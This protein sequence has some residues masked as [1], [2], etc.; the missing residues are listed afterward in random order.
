MSLEL[1]YCI[2]FTYVYI[3]LS[4]WSWWPLERS[5]AVRSLESFPAFYGTALTRSLHLYLSWTRRIQSTS[6]HPMPTRSILTLSVHLHHVL[7]SVLFLSGYLTN[8]LYAVSSTHSCY[9]PSPPHPPRLDDSNYTWRK[10]LIV[11]LFIVQFSPSLFGQNILVSTP[12]LS[13]L[14]L[15]SS[16]NVREII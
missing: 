8:N 9:M 3:E 13:T 12:F 11:Q 6:P 7:P 14:S 10:M 4:L 15:C 1:I 16:L 2:I 5:P